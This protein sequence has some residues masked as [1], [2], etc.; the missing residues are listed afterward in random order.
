MIHRFVI[1]ELHRRAIKVDIAAK[2]STGEFEIPSEAVAL[3]RIVRI[4]NRV[5]AVRRNNTPR[6][7][8]IETSTDNKVLV[9]R[10]HRLEIL[11]GC[12][13]DSS[14]FR[15]VQNVTDSEPMEQLERV[16]C[17]KVE[18]CV[19]LLKIQQVLQAETLR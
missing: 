12:R 19:L 8:R 18:S 13:I 4:I 2:E 11:L 16:T 10:C 6:M 15:I 1:A 14:G 9:L 3:C 7:E 17:R 5:V